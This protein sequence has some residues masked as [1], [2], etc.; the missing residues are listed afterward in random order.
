VATVCR[1]RACE[2][3]RLPGVR[4]VVHFT[5]CWWFSTAHNRRRPLRLRDTTVIAWESASQVS[6][7]KFIAQQIW[8]RTPGRGEDAYGA[9]AFR[10]LDHQARITLGAGIQ[11]RIF[12][13]PRQ[14]AESNF[15]RLFVGRAAQTTV[16]CYSF[17]FLFIFL[18]FALPDR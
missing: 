8:D 15:L 4:V 1:G 11:A 3:L 6:W 17:L 10:G 16:P 12:L 13:L 5:Q 14:L 9:F 18:M 2:N 7:K